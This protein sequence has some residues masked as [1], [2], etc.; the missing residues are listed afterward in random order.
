MFYSRPIVVEDG[1]GCSFNEPSVGKERSI[2]LIQFSDQFK[3]WHPLFKK[4]LLSQR[5]IFK[6]CDQVTH[7]SPS[8]WNGGFEE[9]SIVPKLQKRIKR[10][11]LQFFDPE[12]ICFQALFMT[13]FESWMGR[14]DNQAAE[15]FGM[16]HRKEA[17]E[18][19]PHGI[20]EKGER[21]KMERLKVEL[22]DR[23]FKGQ[24]RQW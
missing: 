8:I 9:G 5:Q 12:E 13:C 6:Q 22:V 7:L 4:G 23:L 24:S 18:P 14:C 21:G 10:K 17:S 3:G 2:S 19:S 11:S 15:S 20:S 16:D 1:V